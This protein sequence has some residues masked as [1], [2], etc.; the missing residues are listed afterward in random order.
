MEALQKLVEDIGIV[1]HESLCFG[2]DQVLE[3]SRPLKETD[4]SIISVTVK[5]AY[6]ISGSRNTLE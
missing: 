4:K 1:L 2:G 6:G 3:Q 5:S